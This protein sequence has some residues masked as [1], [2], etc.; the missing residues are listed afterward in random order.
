MAKNAISFLVVDN[1]DD[2][3]INASIL[4]VEYGYSVV[5]H[6]SNASDALEFLK[7]NT[8]D[9]AL[10]DI[11]LKNGIDGVA[12]AGILQNQFQTPIVFLTSNV[13]DATFD[14]AK[15]MHP[16]AFLPKPI[17]PLDL[18]RAIALT[19]NHISGKTAE[20]ADTSYPNET[21][22]SLSDRI[23]VHHG[24]KRVKI[25]LETILYIEAERNYCRI[26]TSSKEYL[27]SMPMKSLEESLPHNQFQRIHRSHIINLSHID[28]LDDHSVMIGLKSLTISKSYQQQLMQRIKSI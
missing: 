3:L 16:F 28:A 18:K 19:I 27:L 7:T 20:A 11:Q 13:D 14:R 5:G 12:L 26:V 17:I 22:I 2:P 23:F 9:I 15:E 24:D 10:I 1:G 4:L 25:L 8:V 21:F 6:Y